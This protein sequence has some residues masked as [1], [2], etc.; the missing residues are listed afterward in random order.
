MEQPYKCFGEKSQSSAHR[1][2]AG[3]RGPGVKKITMMVAVWYVEQQE[4]AVDVD[5]NEPSSIRYA[6]EITRGIAR[7][8]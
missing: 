7:I 6:N 2:A 8:A 1:V 3:S 5:E 4:S